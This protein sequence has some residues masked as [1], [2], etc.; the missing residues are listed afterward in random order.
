MLLKSG[1]TYCCYISEELSGVSKPSH[2][3]QRS[4]SSQ[5]SSHNVG[6][7]HPHVSAEHASIAATGETKELFPLTG[8]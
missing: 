2:R 7:F 4:T 5:C 1:A 6:V 8:S 3:Q